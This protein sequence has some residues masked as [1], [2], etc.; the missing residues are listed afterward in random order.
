MADGIL[1][2]GT[3]TTSSGSGNITIGS[4]VTL[5]SN[6][7]IFFGQL[8]SDQTVSSGVQTLVNIDSVSFD[9]N[10]NWDSSA[11]KWTPDQPG[12]YLVYGSV[13]CTGSTNVE[14]AMTAI[15][16]N[17][18]EVQECQID[19]RTANGDPVNGG[20]TFVSIPLS[21]NGTSDYVQLYG[22]NLGGTT[23][24]GSSDNRTFLGAYKLTGA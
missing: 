24:K 1:K 11:Y 5:N 14:L 4:G 23:F 20:N 12:T 3:I 2:V 17:G 7:P 15:Y 18:A 21:M 9:S 6:T 13:R 16:K 19:F 8:T 10:S 22:R